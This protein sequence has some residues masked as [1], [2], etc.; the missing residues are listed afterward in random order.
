MFPAVSLGFGPNIEFYSPLPLPD[1]I[2][3]PIL[4][5]TGLHHLEVVIEILYFYATLS[6]EKYFCKL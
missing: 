3:A 4:D 1:T 6:Y 2:V 5:N